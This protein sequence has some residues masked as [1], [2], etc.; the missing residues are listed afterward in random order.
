M[1]KSRVSPGGY[2]RIEIT[3]WRRSLATLALIVSTAVWLPL[4]VVGLLYRLVLFNILSVAYFV[5]EY[6]VR[7]CAVR[8]ELAKFV[9]TKDD[10]TFAMVPRFPARYA[11]AKMERQAHA[12]Q[13]LEEA[14]QEQSD[15]N[16]SLGDEP[17]LIHSTEVTNRDGYET[18]EIDDDEF[19][20]NG[21]KH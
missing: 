7:Y 5:L 21:Y 6:L 1:Q 4:F 14:P 10:G 16:D 8:M 12:M 9:M 2:K 20:G 18:I 13:T 11:L 17:G 15:L 19:G 3:Q